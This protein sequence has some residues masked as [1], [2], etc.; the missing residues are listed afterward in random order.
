M[1]GVQ[2]CALPICDDYFISAESKIL[3]VLNE[4]KYDFIKPDDL[5]STIFKNISSED[6]IT[7]LLDEKKIIKLNEECITSQEIYN[8]AKKLA[9]E[10]IKSNGKITAAEYRDILNTNRKN[11]ILLL[12]YFDLARIT[13]RNGNDRVLF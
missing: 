11:A 12:E 8:N 3:K 2:T 1:T 6:V 5:K 13:K 10:Y 4:A 7:V 9:V